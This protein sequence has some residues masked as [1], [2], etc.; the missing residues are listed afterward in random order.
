MSAGTLAPEEGLTFD[1][2][3]RQTSNFHSHKHTRFTSLHWPM[4]EII[5]FPTH[6]A[7][8]AYAELISVQRTYDVSLVIYSSISQHTACMRTLIGE[9]KK[10]ILV[11]PDAD[12]FAFHFRDCNIVFTKAELGF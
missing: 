10:R 6:I 11:S 3:N 7:A 2:F 1:D 9:R 8:V 4:P 12:D 5:S